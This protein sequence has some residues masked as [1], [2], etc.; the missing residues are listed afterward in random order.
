MTE[1]R[2]AGSDAM[3]PTLSE[4]KKKPSDNS[5]WSIWLVVVS[6]V[7]LGYIGSNSDNQ[8][9]DVA[10]LVGYYLPS[11]LLIFGVFY[12]LLLRK[13]GRKAAAV[14]FVA[15]YLAAIFGG[16]IAAT[17][18]REQLAQAI[19]SIE[20]QYSRMVDSPT[21]QSEIP[22]SAEV[23][24][25]TGQL[26]RGTVGE[27]E[28]FT[29][30]FMDQLVAQRNDYML[31]LNAIGWDSILEPPRYQI[32]KA[33]SEKRMKIN[34]GK[35]IVRKYRAR[36]NALM[37]TTR[38]KIDDLEISPSLKRDMIAG[39][40]R[41]MKNT[42]SRIDRVWV[43]EEMTVAEVE[44]IINLLSARRG[45]WTVI[46]KKIL[47]DNDDDLRRYNRYLANIRQYEVEQE[48]IQKQGIDSVKEYF[49]AARESLR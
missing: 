24:S 29:K 26:S 6:L 10:H 8:R 37:Q 36:T 39:F 3:V 5:L 40:D 7:V 16:V 38:S 46:G 44:G 19:G 34:K 48:K 28:R 31:E 17:R 22:K 32:D 49:S 27:F 43:L 9:T 35:E 12:Y 13:Q 41:G 45:S 42:Q 30:E 1:E 4:L 15:I 23:R 14:S 33:L 11:S 21:D 47:F 2:D 20:K 25:N 18:Q